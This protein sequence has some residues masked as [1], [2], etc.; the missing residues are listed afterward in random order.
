MKRA[1]L[2]LRIAAPAEGGR[3]V[4][5]ATCR[6]DVKMDPGAAVEKVEF[7]LDENSFVEAMGPGSEP[8][9]AR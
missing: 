3:V 7:S 9:A 6:A 8:T 4:G 1:P 5:P 2:E